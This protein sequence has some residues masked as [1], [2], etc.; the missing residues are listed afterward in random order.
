MNVIPNSYF[1]LIF[2]II[3]LIISSRDFKS[4]LNIVF[5]YRLVIKT[6]VYE[7]GILTDGDDDTSDN[8]TEI[9]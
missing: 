4:V 9:S 7:V 3:Y 5:L 6:I 1:F 8:S 2:N